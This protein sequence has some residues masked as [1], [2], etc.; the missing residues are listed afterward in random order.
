MF[1]WYS[2]S[3]VCIVQLA[4]TTDSVSSLRNDQWFTR[5]WTLQELLAPKSVKF[6]DKS[7]QPITSYFLT[8]DDKYIDSNSKSH[9]WNH[10]SHI[11]GISPAQIYTFDSGIGHA[12]DALVWL[13]KRQTTRI[14][15]MAYC[16]IG[17][18]GIP[19]TIAYGEGEMAFYRLQVEILQRTPDMGIF[20]WKGQ[21][22]VGNSMLAAKPDSFSS[23]TFGTLSSYT[24]E[25]DVDLSYSF[26]NFGL[27]IPLLVYQ[28]P[29]SELRVVHGNEVDTL[30]MV[31][32][33]STSV[34]LQSRDN[35]EF[36]ELAF[37]GMIDGQE[38]DLAILLGFKHGQWKR[39][40][41]DYI[42]LPLPSG[43][44]L[45]TRFIR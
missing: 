30:V 3:K 28:I 40:S 22:A 33:G 29:A 2:K 38:M 11:T 20:I 25:D 41:K 26:T 16:L 34:E 18:L 14:E 23:P 45:Q 42:I 10:I 13:S 4:D 21:S 1:N 37:L 8:D 31:N 32:L 15:D 43:A 9:L 36:V 24:F 7:W 35:Y 19:L 6:F 44:A 39:I 12:R 27:R 17:L 5:G